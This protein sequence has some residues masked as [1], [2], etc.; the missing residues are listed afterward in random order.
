M[1]RVGEHGQGESVWLAW[2][3]ARVATDFA[4][5]CEPRG[6][7][8]P[9]R[10][11][12]R[13]GDAGSA[14]AADAEAWDGA[15]YRRAYFDDGTPMG[16]AANEECRIDAIAQSWSVI[17][18]VGDPERARQAMASLARAPDARRRRPAA[19]ADA[20]VRQERA[21]PR[22]HPRL[23]AGRARERRAVH[24]RRDLDG[25]GDGAARRRD[26]RPRS[27]S[28]TS[29]R[30]ATARRPR[31]SRR[32][33]VEPYVVAADV[34][35]NAQHLGR[36]GWTWYTGSAGWLYRLATETILGLRLIG[37]R[38]RIDPTIP[39]ALGRASRR[40]CA[41]TRSWSRTRTASAAGSRGSRSTAQAGRGRRAAR[42]GRPRAH[43]QGRARPEG[44]D[45]ARARR[46]TRSRAGTRRPD[47]GPS[48][49]GRRRQTGRSG[50]ACP[51]R[52]AVMRAEAARSA[53]H[54]RSAPPRSRT[55]RRPRPGTAPPGPTSSGSPTRPSGVPGREALEGARLRAP[56]AAAQIGVRIE[57]GQITFARTA[58]APV[59]D[60]QVLASG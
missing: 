34:Y 41:A 57:P 22:L 45:P 2:F 46:P 36:G 44:R 30:S 38:L 32:Y 51:C 49:P 9:R 35:A 5:I 53:R 7:A 3:L 47:P 28:A 15:W 29:T 16:S 50:S 58:L 10:G 21:R 6:D 43:G 59:A 13:P 37:G 55:R 14:Q 19:A 31:R 11:A 52:S 23:P 26:A 42:A 17:A 48:L 1:N 33:K 8:G 27:C 40:G 24:P 4:P 60:G 18:G 25:P 54:R 56:A 20:A 12:S 39:R